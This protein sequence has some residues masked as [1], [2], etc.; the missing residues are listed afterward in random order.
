MV[1]ANLPASPIYLAD[2]GEIGNRKVIQELVRV[3]EIKRLATLKLQA[4]RRH[5]IHRQVTAASGHL[6]DDIGQRAG[7][8]RALV[9]RLAHDFNHVGHHL[10]RDPS[11]D[12]T[13]F[14]NIGEFE[15]YL[16]CES[17]WF[18]YRLQNSFG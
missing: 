6:T 18:I 10:V 9:H 2:T 7:A 1:A 14:R 16:R 4:T 12:E 15:R 11:M 5:Q 17:P 3:F 8:E 13:K